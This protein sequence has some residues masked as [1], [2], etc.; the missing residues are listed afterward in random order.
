MAHVLPE[1]LSAIQKWPTIA[2]AGGGHHLYSPRRTGEL[3]SRG[4]NVVLVNSSRDLL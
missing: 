2:S 1:E 3:G 4:H